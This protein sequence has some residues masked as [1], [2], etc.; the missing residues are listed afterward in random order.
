MKNIKLHKISLYVSICL[1]AFIAGYS[2]IIDYQF[3]EDQI[4]YLFSLF[5]MVLALNFL[6]GDLTIDNR[7]ER[8]RLILTNTRSVIISCILSIL[9]ALILI[10]SNMVI[11]KIFMILVLSILVYYSTIVFF[12]R[13]VTLVLFWINFY[14]FMGIYLFS[15]FPD[16]KIDMI[17]RFNPLGGLLI[18]LFT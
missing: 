2:L 11:V 18:T 13:K 15:Q 12:N 6:G 5:Y 3:P 10:Q 8:I 4:N 17:S 9:F 1:I 7:Q 16:F 14:L